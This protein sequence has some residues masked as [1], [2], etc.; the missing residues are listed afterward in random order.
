VSIDEHA[1]R[2][3]GQQEREE[4]RRAQ[5]PDLGRARGQSDDRQ[6]G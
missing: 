3:R 5:D 1:E 4:L 2:Q 6:E